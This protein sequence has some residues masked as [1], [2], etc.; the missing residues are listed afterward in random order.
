M[1]RSLCIILTL[2]IF[3]LIGV[4]QDS[5]ISR[6]ILIG[7]AGEINKGQQFIIQDAL[8]KAIPGKTIVLYLGDNIYPQGIAL[9]GSSNET[10]TGTH[11][12]LESQY[13]LFRENNIPVYFIPGNHD[14]DRSGPDGF[15][16][17]QEESAYFEAQNDSMLRLIP[18]NGCPGPYEVN[19]SDSVVIIAL[20]SEWWL[21]PFNR[22]EPGA[23]DCACKTKD[24]IVAKLEQLLYKNRYKVVLLATHHPFQTNGSHGGYHPLK[25]HIFP[26]TV[27]NKY[28]YIP[29]PVVGS[30]YPLLRNAFPSTE[31][32]RHPL[33][34]SFIRSIYAATKS[35][36]NIIRVS[37]HEHGLQLILDN[38]IQVVSGAAS[39]ST[40]LKA[41]DSFALKTQ[42]YVIADIS[43]GNNV[44][45]SYY[46]VKDISI[47]NIFNYTKAYTNIKA[48][49]EQTYSSQNTDSITLPLY[50]AY[51]SV[52]KL[53]RFFLGKNYRKEWAQPTKIPVLQL[54][55]DARNFTAAERGGG[56]QT[57]SL[58][59]VDKDGK[60][61]SLRS[62]EKFPDVVV[63][64]PL[65]QTFVS[66]VV[67]DNLS[68]S[69]PFAALT[70]PDI[71]NAVQVPHSNP[72]IVYVA[73][74]DKLGIYNKD[75]ANTINLL[76]EREPAGKSISTFNLQQV[77]QNDNDN[78]VDQPAFLKAKL[79]DIL[80]GDWDRH[81][82]QWRWVA[83]KSGKGKIYKPVPRDRDQVFYI[84]EGVLPNIASRPWLLPYLQGF[85]KKINNP[86]T[87]N[88]EGRFMHAR[89]LNNISYSAW[90]QTAKDFVSQVTDS[91]FEKALSNLPPKAYQLRHDEL[92]EKLKARRSNLVNAAERFYLFQ[93]KILDIEGSDK[94]ELILLKDTL[95][96][97]LSVNIFK[98]SKKNKTEDIL[99]NRVFDPAVTKQVNIYLH[100]GD[101]SIIINK[102]SSSV[103]VRFIGGNGQKQFNLTGAENVYVY[104]KPDSIFFTGISN[105][106]KHLSNKPAN[107]AVQITNLYNK[108]IPSIVAGYNLDDG[109]ILGIGVHHIQQQGF[110]KKPFASAQKISVAH[111]IAT[112]AYRI[113]YSGEWIK[114]FGNADLVLQTTIKAPDNT[115]NFF[116]SGNETVYDQRAQKNISLYRARYNIYNFEPSLRWAGKKYSSLYLGSSFQYY[117]F[118]TSDNTNKI[119]GNPAL[120]KTYDSASIIKNKLHAGVFVNY[121]LDT[122][123]N[124]I[125]PSWGAYVNIR[126]QACAG[127]NNASES[128]MQIIPEVSLYK[129]VDANSAVV[130]ANRIGGGIS[131]GKP[132]FYQS[133]FIGG[134]ENL[135]GYRQYRFAGTHSLYNNFEARIRLGNFASYILPGQVGLVT[136]FDVGRVWQSGE[137][138]NKWHTGYG[139][140]LYFAP[141]R[142]A[143]LQFV[144]AHSIEGWYPHITLGFR[145]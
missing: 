112:D 79:L 25:E 90:M 62:I 47:K 132:A 15:K 1:R 78:S 122:R 22:R 110:R 88:F 91:V 126:L 142:I 129:S 38:G 87:F 44:R 4:A 137:T 39:K 12:I 114:V 80:L 115:T 113:K 54:S 37:G 56:H 118:D 8:Q 61:W 130:I 17:I 141:A 98:L 121:I 104:N 128:F 3:Q 119:I 83:E 86:N 116:G 42:G 76:E 139:A 19:V 77:L 106:K 108:T 50:A 138:S 75:F 97:Q 5:I 82:D 127:L 46:G 57:K 65:R 13:K 59:L 69:N 9:P 96:D 58:K 93:N 107:T 2:L 34:K 14:W 48:F 99:Y 31:D 105:I 36:P 32:L 66:D 84:N 55:K 60:E 135:L 20:D 64:E 27:V 29:L 40:P 73:A 63:P 123:N 43:T 16:K 23:N 94:N 26:L 53:H 6:I 124:K 81:E 49:E 131:F 35:Y 100:N 145:F 95:N 125:L 144:A 140:G 89:W 7:D 45:L 74:D 134:H 92:L 10:K 24:E 85:N 101:D 103:K 70:I 41:K 18:S 68:S 120:I 33:Y 136:F 143:V 51:D 117:H 72:S 11:N 133:M 28:L 111:S 102:N 109:L 67:K 21:Y 52:T 30:L 71:A